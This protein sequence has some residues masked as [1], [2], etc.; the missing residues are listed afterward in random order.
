MYPMTTVSVSDLR[1]D[2]ARIEALLQRGEEIRITK[3]GKAVGRL[4]PGPP[5]ATPASPKTAP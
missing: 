2:F 1:H 5:P 4:L 3:Y